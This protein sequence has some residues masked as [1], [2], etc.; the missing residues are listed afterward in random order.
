MD[1]YHI[2]WKDI[3]LNATENGLT[4]L[5]NGGKAISNGVEFAGTYSP[6]GHLTLGL[7]AAYTDAHLTSVIPN[8]DY[9][10][11]GYQL[12]DVPKENVSVTADYSWQLAGSWS[13][14]VGGGYRYVGKEWLSAVESASASTTPTVQASG[15]SVIDLN[16]SLRNDHLTIKAY[17]R[18]LANDRAI[19]GA[20]QGGIGQKLVVTNSAT[21]VSQIMTTFLQPRTVGL[22]VDYTF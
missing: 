6:I 9:L 10:L 17:V 18:N 11:T 12:P 1:I 21:G 13:S 7:N 3:Q 19:T 22:G 20:A 2:D 14:V 8:A 16:A 15:Y 4:Y 5:A